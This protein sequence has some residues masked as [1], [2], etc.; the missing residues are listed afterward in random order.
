M[1]LSTLPQTGLSHI[2]E[3]I[4]PPLTDFSAQGKVKKARAGKAKS[5]LFVSDP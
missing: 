1:G 5:M 4:D 2:L 3:L